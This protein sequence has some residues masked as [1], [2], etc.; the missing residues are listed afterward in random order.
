VSATDSTQYFFE[1]TPDRVL[2]AVELSGLRCTGRC[3]ALNSFENRVYE[4]ELDPEFA[5]AGD[6]P[7]WERPD[8]RVAKFYRPGRWS[9]AQILEEHQF[10]A[11]LLAA[12]VPAVAPIPFPDGRT[13]H[14]SPEGIW[15]AVFPKVGGRAPDEFSDEQLLRVGRLLGRI[16]NVG[17]SRAAP[18]RVQLTP[19]TYGTENLEFLLRENFVPLEYRGRYEKAAR[20][21]IRRIEPSFQGVATHRVH[22]DCHPG[23]LLWNTHGLFFLDL[24]DMVTAPAAQDLWLLIPGRDTEAL[25]QRDVILEGY[26]EMRQFDR[27]TLGLIEGLRALRFIHYTAWIARRWKDPAFPQAFPEFGSHPYWAGETEDL[28]EQLRQIDG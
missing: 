7:P 12:E 10:L 21:I 25:R 2:A 4:V 14:K 27:S 13:L 26:S 20:E 22:G 23:N 18:H 15:Y 17:A 28:L 6:R 19:T 3:S 8:R 9:E 5:S 1:L 24:D 11:D 16:H